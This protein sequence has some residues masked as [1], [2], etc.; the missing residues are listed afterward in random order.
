MGGFLG[1]NEMRLVPI[2]VDLEM[3]VL[4]KRVIAGN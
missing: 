2:L 1:R 4:S 3:I